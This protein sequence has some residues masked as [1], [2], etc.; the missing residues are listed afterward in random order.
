MQVWGE[1]GHKAEVG[2]QDRQE[3]A[4][5]Q[6]LAIW[7]TPPGP[8][9]LRAAVEQVSPETIYL[10]GIDPGLDDVEGFLQ[11][12]AGLVKRAQNA[13]GG[14]VRV[15]TL[16]A[17][18]AQREATVRTGLAWLASRGHVS[19]LERDEGEGEVRLVAGSKA[20]AADLSRVTARLRELLQETAAYRA[21]FAGADEEILVSV[22]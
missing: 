9:E 18:T 20:A 5:A 6:V 7:T 16:A 15:S 10:F 4:T 19:V 8:G 13:H 1:A 21:Y 14:W 11:R 2:G 17:A 22:R 12:L 3:L